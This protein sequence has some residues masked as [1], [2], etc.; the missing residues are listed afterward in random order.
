MVI[1]AKEGVAAAITSN[2]GND[3]THTILKT[4]DGLD[5]KGIDD[6]QIKDLLNAVIQGTDRPSTTNILEL[7]VAILAFQFNFQKKVKANVE[8][9]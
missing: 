3:V 4:A 6:Y 7:L 9:L 2:V 8:I 1:G 5:Y